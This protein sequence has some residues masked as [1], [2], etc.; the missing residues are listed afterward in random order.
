[1]MSIS[2]YQNTR[3][4]KF[5]E[6]FKD[7][8]IEKY[9]ELDKYSDKNK[10]YTKINL[11]IDENQH[12]IFLDFQLYKKN[13]FLN[14][15]KLP[16]EIN[17]EIYNYYKREFIKIN[18]CIFYGND[19]PFF[20]PLWNLL[21]VKHNLDISINLKQYYSDIIN[22][23]NNLNKK[24]WSPAIDLTQDMLDFIQKINHFEYMLN[25]VNFIYQT[26]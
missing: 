6:I 11:K 9:F 24:D 17:R 14:F 12:K 3:I 25:N 16:D 20:P 23:H 26:S 7:T 4:S 2:S 1:M 5:Q 19:Y 18:I 13:N 21:N 22:Y 15:I 8:S 10:I